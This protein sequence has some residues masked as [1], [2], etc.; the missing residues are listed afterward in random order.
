MRTRKHVVDKRKNPVSPKKDN[1]SLVKKTT[2]IFWG[3][4]NIYILENYQMIFTEIRKWL[5]NYIIDVYACTLTK[6]ENSNFCPNTILTKS[7]LNLKKMDN[8]IEKDFNLY[9]RAV[10]AP[11]LKIHILTKEAPKVTLWYLDFTFYKY[12]LHTI[13]NI[14]AVIHLLKDFMMIGQL[15]AGSLL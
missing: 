13:W 10:E 5:S 4:N 7:P 3:H 15:F 9:A 2:I 11:R 14:G 8:K 12:V 6:C 1:L